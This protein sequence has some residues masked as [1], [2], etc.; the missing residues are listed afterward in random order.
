M[1]RVSLAGIGAIVGAESPGMSDSA[2]VTFAAPFRASKSWGAVEQELLV[3]EPAEFS[4]PV[5]STR[6]L[7]PAATVWFDDGNEACGLP[8]VSHE[9]RLFRPLMRDDD[10]YKSLGGNRK[11]NYPLLAFEDVWRT[12]H[13]LT[14]LL[15]S[16]FRPGDALTD[17]PYV[18]RG[19]PA[20]RQSFAEARGRV[21]AILASRAFV[22]D[23]T[24]FHETVTP[25]W[26]F[27]GCRG[28]PLSVCIPD[29]DCDYR[30][31][32]TLFD[33]RL[34]V[35]RIEETV[36][37]MLGD[38]VDLRSPRLR[39]GRIEVHDADL[40]PDTVGRDALACFCVNMLGSSA[41]MTLR[42]H[43]FDVAT[44]MDALVDL[45]ER[46]ARDRTSL[47]PCLD[48]VRALANW[49]DCG[50]QRGDGYDFEVYSVVSTAREF[51]ELHDALPPG[52][53]RPDEREYEEAV[54]GFRP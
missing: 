13:R 32:S 45:V 23:G 16:P 22:A 52:P 38:R 27:S 2:K 34:D 37:P 21:Q 41:A 50:D 7:K 28:T 18:K 31:G 12:G 15:A 49:E 44:E 26:G 35:A 43:G 17:E 40:L 3:S 8:Y 39:E 53:P 14:N 42:R 9:G 4:V 6:D 10:R 36:V 46:A 33:P 47:E 5:L 25:G 1:R 54:A 11:S 51:I 29:Y 30:V 24:L 20:A 48:A 19:T